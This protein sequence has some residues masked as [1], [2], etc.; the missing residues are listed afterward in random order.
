MNY[1]RLILVLLVAAFTLAA[2]D[3]GLIRLMPKDPTMVAGIDLE[4]AKGSPF[5]QRILLEMKDEEPQLQKFIAATGFDPR[6][7]IREVV[8]SASGDMKTG[9][10]GNALV[11]V[12]GSFDASK[13]TRWMVSEGGVSG[14]YN[15]VELVRPKQ[16]EKSGPPSAIAF[17]DNSLALVGDELMVKEAI[18]RRAA[19]T[20]GLN[21]DMAA[22]VAEWSSKNDAW[23]VSSPALA[24]VGVGSAESNNRVL[25]GGVQ[26][27]A[28]R[29]AFAGVRFGSI[30]E[31]N[32][33]T[34]M[35]SD[36]DATALAD[37][38]RFLVTMLRMNADKP[39][40][41]EL[42]RIAES[43]QVSTAGNTFRFAISIPE[44]QL[45]KL[46]N[47]KKKGRAEKVA[48]AR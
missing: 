2:A 44:T 23:F 27:D 1:R 40:M 22:R 38:A 33:E 6:K 45:E 5:G 3:P 17:L 34:L 14:V 37:V 8:L 39:G 43:M 48:L 18:D 9:P 7:D 32:A 11:A 15:G 25:P 13:L 47:D 28:V 36:K 29:Q 12:R 16:G 19:N 10:K 41:E 35:R 24:D 4:R 31:I 20:P 26:L 30:L 42:I 46:L 21:A